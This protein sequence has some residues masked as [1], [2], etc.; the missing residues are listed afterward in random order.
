MYDNIG[1]KIKAFAKVICIIGIVISCLVGFLA[2]LGTL[3][4]SSAVSSY[5]SRASSN[6]AGAG[7]IGGLLYAG[8]GSLISWLSTL[9][10]YGFGHL[11]ETQEQSA[12]ALEQ[13]RVE[14]RRSSKP[15]SISPAGS[16]YS[17]SMSSATVPNGSSDQIPAWKRVEMA[18]EKTEERKCRNCGTP[19]DEGTA[20]CHNCGS[21]L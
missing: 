20:F 8:L 13:I 19:Y 18:Q 16:S 6:L 5:S 9:V 3:S 7:I 21:K 1:G 14:L 15:D 2:I 4:A 10:L 17:P 11:V 12:Y